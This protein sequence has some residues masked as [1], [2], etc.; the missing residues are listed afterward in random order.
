M[1]QEEKKVSG[2]QPTCCPFVGLAPCHSSSNPQCPWHP[3]GLGQS[4]EN[5][6]GR[7]KP[8][9][10]SPHVAVV[11]ANSR[12]CC[13]QGWPGLCWVHAPRVGKEAP[14]PPQAAGTCGAEW[15]VLSQSCHRAVAF[16]VG[17]AQDLSRG[18]GET[19]VVGETWGTY[20][21][22]VDLWFFMSS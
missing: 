8:G 15:I 19:G 18:G 3:S 16:T 11:P 9:H 12:S 21:P 4:K 1:F 22:Y 6:L 14:L 20:D 2:C 10:R 5:G 13:T 17:E 7:L